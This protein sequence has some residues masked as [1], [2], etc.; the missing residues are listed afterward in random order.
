MQENEVKEAVK[1]ALR[2]L[3]ED[4]ITRFRCD[5]EVNLKEMARELGEDIYRG[6]GDKNGEYNL[7]TFGGVNELY[8][9]RKHLYHILGIDCLDKFSS[10][11]E[12]VN[13]WFI[14]I[15]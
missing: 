9:Q 10:L 7:L 8:I 15:D 6:K 5:I 14:K 3:K 13:D 1:T 12:L 11:Y 2:E 4:G